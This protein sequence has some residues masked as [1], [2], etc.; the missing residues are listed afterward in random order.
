MNL[1]TLD[2]PDDPARL[3][4]WL[5]EQLLSPDLMDTIMELEILAGESKTE[6]QKLADILGEQKQAILNSG[7]NATQFATVA[8]LLKQP[9]LLLQLQEEVLMHGGDFWQ[10]KLR[11]ESQTH[12]SSILELTQQ[13]ESIDQARIPV[14]RAKSKFS[15]T[16]IVGIVAAMAATL[17]VLFSLLP[18]KTDN[19]QI[20]QND[21][22]TK[23]KTQ[24]DTPD[25]IPPAN[26]VVGSD[27]PG[28]GF[29]ESGVLVADVGEQEM[30]KTLS[31]ATLSWY[32]KPTTSIKEL[33]ARLNQ[34]DEGCQQLLVAELPQLESATRDAIFK[35]CEDCRAS[36]ASQLQDIKRGIDFDVALLSAEANI[37]RLNKAIQDLKS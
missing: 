2:M 31:A 27:K 14:A 28:W 1:K 3:G 36:I 23:P 32:N 22:S 24:I 37:E 16:R 6:D 12:Q 30:L 21:G 25:P 8:D 20:A 18:E 10:K 26:D 11:V 5:D 13:A 34:F 4:A 9:D 17:L 19:G 15:T 33:E 29:A 35:A 7:L